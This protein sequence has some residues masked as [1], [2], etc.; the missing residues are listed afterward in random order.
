[1]LADETTNRLTEGIDCTIEMQATTSSGDHNPLWLN[2]NKYGL[3]SIE[4]NNGYLRASVVRDKDN[5]SLRNWA[6]GYGLDI[7]VASHFTSKF[8]VQQAFFEGRYKRGVLTIGSKHHTMNLKNNEL[9]SG[10]QTLGINARPFPEVR[11]EMPDYWD[12]PGLKGWLAFRGHLAYGCQTDDNWQRNF[13]NKESKYTEHTL[14]HSKSGFLR[15]APDS[16]PLQFELGL[17]WG[18]QFGGKSY[19]INEDGV[20]EELCNQQNLSSFWHAF[21]PDF[22]TVGDVGEGVYANCTG[23]HV[24]SWLARLTYKGKGW[25]IAA[26]LDHYF[27]D[28]SQLLFVDYDGYGTGEDWDKKKDSRYLL[29]KFKDALIGIEATLPKNRIASTIVAEYMHTKYQSGPI[30]HD[31][32]PSSP[33]H[34]AGKDNYYNHYIYTGWQHWGQVIGNPLYTS[35]IYNNDGTIEVKNNRFSAFHCGLSGDPTPQLHYRLMATWQKGYGT[36][37]EPFED[38]ESNFSLLAEAHYDLSSIDWLKG[39]SVVGAFALDRGE[40]LGDNTGFQFTIAKRF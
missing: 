19:Q 33:T 22:G 27:E 24:G 30:F 9:S 29:Y 25:K 12:I 6:V 35:P 3:S 1:M 36:Y 5:D 16:K 13:T 11:V 18:C 38:P 37:Q 26:Y 32:T 28:H 17:E 4:N 15:I 7:A 8:I 23:N 34:I 31:H 10:S 40:L 20:M 14:Y 21:V 2:A 39:V